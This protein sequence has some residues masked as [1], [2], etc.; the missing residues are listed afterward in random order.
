MLITIPLHLRTSDQFALVITSKSTPTR[1]VPSTES[2][3]D[4]WL[5]VGTSLIITELVSWKVLLMLGGKSIYGEKFADEN[6]KIKHEKRGQ[7]SMANAG[8]NTNG[9]QFFITFLDTEWLNGNHTVFGELVEGDKVLDAVEAVG[10]R[11]GT[12]SEKVTVVDCGEIKDE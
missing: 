8:P 2:S 3:L 1:T 10:S 12:T 9:S 6:M 5:K 4:S 7:L 11:S